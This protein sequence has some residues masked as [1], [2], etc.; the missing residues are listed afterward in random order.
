MNNT[1]VA[2]EVVTLDYAM[3]NNI[4]GCNLGLGFLNGSRMCHACRRNW[5]RIGQHQCAKCPSGEQN[6]LIMCAGILTA[7]LGLSAL[8]MMTLGEKGQT[9][10][11]G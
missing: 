11:S 1:D 6:W 8:V 5:R 2:S 10:L 7:C 3:Q 9:S 4:E